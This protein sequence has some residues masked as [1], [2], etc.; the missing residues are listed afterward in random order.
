M[1]LC[2][3]IAEEVI[4]ELADQR[5]VINDSNPRHE[6]SPEIEKAACERL[7]YQIPETYRLSIGTIPG[8][9]KTNV[10]HSARKT[11]A[12]HA[13]VRSVGVR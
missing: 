4:D 8:I 2:S 10:L 9:H 12:I 13:G 6:G 7:P 5:L 3:S 1:H 11:I